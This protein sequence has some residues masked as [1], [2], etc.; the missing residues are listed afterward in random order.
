MRL[1][2]FPFQWQLTS[3]KQSCRFQQF[4]SAWGASHCQQR[5]RQPL[6]PTTFQGMGFSWAK[7]AAAQQ[8]PSCFP[9]HSLASGLRT[10]PVYLNFLHERKG[11]VSSRK[12]CLCSIWCS[13]GILAVSLPVQ[14]KVEVPKPQEH[15]VLYIYIYIYMY[16]YLKRDVLQ[17]VFHNSERFPS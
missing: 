16:V 2:Q 14:P 3:E 7:A 4:L 1:L 15:K 10:P 13:C 12:L 5:C 11:S 9:H 8:A 17:E 6:P